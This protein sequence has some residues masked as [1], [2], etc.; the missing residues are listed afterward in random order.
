MACARRAPPPATKRA[1]ENDGNTPAKKPKNGSQEQMAEQ[2]ICGNKFMQDSKFCRKCGAPRGQVISE[3]SLC[4]C[5]LVESLCKG[6]TRQ[7]LAALSESESRLQKAKRQMADNETDLKAKT[8][9]HQ[10]AVDAVGEAT[11]QVKLAEDRDKKA[12]DAVAK[13][14]GVRAQMKAALDKATAELANAEDVYKSHFLPLKGTVKESS[15]APW[16]ESS[17]RHV[18]A[19]AP[20]LKAENCEDCLQA[21]F[22]EAASRTPAER[23]AFCNTTVQEVDKLLQKHINGKKANVA[24]ATPPF[25]DAETKSK[26]ARDAKD[27][28][29]ANLLDAMMKHSKAEAAKAEAETAKDKASEALQKSKNDV[30]AATKDRAEKQRDIDA[31]KKLEAELRLAEDAVDDAIKKKLDREA[32]KKNALDRKKVSEK[33]VDRAR[34]GLSNAQKECEKARGEADKARAAADEA[35]AALDRASKASAD[36]EDLYQKH[37]VPIKVGK[38]ANMADVNAHLDALRPTMK[39]LNIEPCL[40]AGFEAAS[41]HTKEERGPFCTKV[42][43]QVDDCMVKHSQKLKNDI[44]A[45]RGPYEKAEAEAKRLRALQERACG[46]GV[47]AAT[48]N[49]ERRQAS[50]D[51]AAQAV[52]VASKELDECTKD[53][54]GKVQIRNKK[55]EEVKLYISPA[56]VR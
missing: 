47:R 32:A 1:A 54:D 55:L 21:G 39:T 10:K 42:V 15:N 8:L 36:F 23:T 2:C 5:P 11:R 16:A 18:D 24:S 33:D 53:L 51:Q 26:D 12:T 13:A 30:D 52:E 3:D 4:Q 34:D 41:C 14:D 6:A 35:K 9:Q 28:A 50:D 7:L 44:A 45:L 25:K 46:D 29:N 27:K 48:E 31:F 43:A 37:F 49:L 38:F 40:L 17:K 19:L 22:K 20:I 56:P